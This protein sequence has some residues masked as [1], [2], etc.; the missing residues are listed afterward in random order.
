MRKVRCHDCGKTYDFDVDDFCPKCGAFTQ[1]KRETIMNIKR[2]SAH[3]NGINEQNHEDSFLHEEYHGENRKRKGS[4]LERTHMPAKKVS[5]AGRI[6]PLG[7]KAG[8]VLLDVACETL[9]TLFDLVD[10]V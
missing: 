7:A 6:K 10:S 1:P 2:G 4:S 3:E 8:N 5:T 9:E